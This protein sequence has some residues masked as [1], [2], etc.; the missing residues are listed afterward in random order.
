MY[1]YIMRYCNLSE[2]YTDMK[3]ICAN[4]NEDAGIKAQAE[5][6]LLEEDT[7]QFYEVVELRRLLADGTTER[8]E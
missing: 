2:H 7:G 6:D 3:A 1:L 5:M 8:L 4:S